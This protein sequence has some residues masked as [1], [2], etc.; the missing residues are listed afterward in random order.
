LMGAIVFI[1]TALIVAIL[2]LSYLLVKK[3]KK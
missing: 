3:T 2:A 1:A